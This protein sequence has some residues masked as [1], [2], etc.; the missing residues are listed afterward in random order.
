M[1]F[2]RTNFEK[3]VPISLNHGSALVG[4]KRFT[5]PIGNDRFAQPRL[6]LLKSPP[7]QAITFLSM[8]ANQSGGIDASA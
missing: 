6:I 2:F 4:G 1:N 7:A 5:S 8:I 3:L